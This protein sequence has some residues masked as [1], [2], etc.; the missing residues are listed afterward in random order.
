MKNKAIK[1]LFAAAGAVFAVAFGISGCHKEPGEITAEKPVIYM[2]QG[3]EANIRI[4]TEKLR[5]NVTYPS[6]QDGWK[7]RQAPDGKHV[8]CGGRT[9]ESLYY[10][11]SMNKRDA[12][13]DISRG[14]CV[15]GSETA[16]FLEKKLKRL[17]LNEDEIN[18]F[19]VY[20]LP[21]MADNPY[22]LISFQSSKYAEM[23]PLHVDPAPGQMIRIYM[24]Y[25]PSG[26]RVEMKQQRL[27]AV[28]R[29]PD[30]YTIVEWG[31]S[32]I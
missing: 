28:T 12:N 27:P 4:G 15:K 22:N 5:L 25:R 11:G 23:V 13:F 8:I 31:G 14:F 3:K 18:E 19:I 21:E 20:W 24:V 30:A 17:G 16:A 1:M 29:D 7:V 2:Y 26:V 32:S 9:Y 6:Y 10:D